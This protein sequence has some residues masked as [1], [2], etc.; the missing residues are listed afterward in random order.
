MRVHPRFSLFT[1]YA[2][3]LCD[4]GRKAEA[5]TVLKQA[6]EDFRQSPRFV[7]RMH[8]G[9]PSEAKRLLAETRR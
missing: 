8:R 6:M 3:L 7:R 4:A 2:R 1:S 9:W 5:Q